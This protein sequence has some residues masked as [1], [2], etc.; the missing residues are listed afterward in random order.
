LMPFLPEPL[1]D[2]NVG[3]VALLLNVA[4]T[5]LVSIA[6]RPGIVERPSAA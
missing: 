6:T 2:L 3:L 1:K 5:A 4:V